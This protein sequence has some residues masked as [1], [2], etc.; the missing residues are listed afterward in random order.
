MLASARFSGPVLNGRLGSSP[1]HLAAAGGQVVGKQFGFNRLGHAARQAESPIVFDAARLNGSFAGAGISGKF[2]GAKA[3]IG[4]VPLLLSDALGQLAFRN[5]DLSVDSALT[6]SDRDANPRFYPLKSNDVHFTLA[7]DYVRATGALRHPASG[8]LVTDVAIEHRLSSGAGHAI[9][10]V[11]GLTFGPEPP[12]RG[13]DPAHRRRH[14]ARQRDDQR[15][16]P[17]RLERRRQGHL[18]RRFLDR[19]TSTSRRRSAR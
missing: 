3:T 11:P 8:T 19:A 1:L 6:V 10:D 18:E 2:S 15:P 17:D 13:A 12:A 7:G 5:S 14:R 4:N 16:G 9:L